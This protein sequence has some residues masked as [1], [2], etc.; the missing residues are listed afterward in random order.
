MSFKNFFENDNQY[1]YFKSN[2]DLE[3]GREL[4]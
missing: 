2:I 1:R 3:T 4:T